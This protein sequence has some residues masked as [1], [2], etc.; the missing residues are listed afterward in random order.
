[1]GDSVAIASARDKGV[2]TAVKT[3]VL[4]SSPRGLMARLRAVEVSLVLDG[5]ALVMAS[6]SPEVLA[7]LGTWLEGLRARKINLLRLS[8]VVL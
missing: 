8:E 5:H 2:R 4:E 3:H 6:P 1:M 7:E